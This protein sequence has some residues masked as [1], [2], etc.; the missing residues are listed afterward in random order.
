MSIESKKQEIT[1]VHVTV[2]FRYRD[3]PAQISTEPARGDHTWVVYRRDQGTLGDH[4]KILAEGPGA[5]RTEALARIR[6]LIDAEHARAALVIPGCED[7]PAD[8]PTF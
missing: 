4:R 7:W 3:Y 5:S 6:A 2:D 1:D 8:G